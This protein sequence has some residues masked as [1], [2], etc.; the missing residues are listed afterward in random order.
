V[1]VRATIRLR[2]FARR[3]NAADE[4]IFRVI[5]EVFTVA[6]AGLF[7][8][9]TPASYPIPPSFSILRGHHQMLISYR[10]LWSTANGRQDT[11]PD[12]QGLG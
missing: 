9:L 11:T 8:K 1:R 6:S 10:A 7:P 2:I 3:P 12:R 5:E 4:N